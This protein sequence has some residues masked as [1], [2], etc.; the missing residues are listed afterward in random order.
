MMVPVQAEARGIRLGAWIART[1]GPDV[2]LRNGIREACFDEM[3][4]AFALM[5]GIKATQGTSK[6]TRSRLALMH[7]HD[8]HLP[9]YDAVLH[10]LA[11]RSVRGGR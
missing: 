3:M 9:S 10:S 6:S 2:L 11:H 5:A 1:L 4:L 7:Q 8:I